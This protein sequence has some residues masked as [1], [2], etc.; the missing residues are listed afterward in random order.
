MSFKLISKHKPSGDQ[1]KAIESLVT[2]IKNGKKNQVLLGATGTGKTF[3]IANVIKNTNKSTIVLSHNKTLAGQLYTELKSLFPEN[4][5]EYFISN[6]DYY[7]PEAYMPSSDTFIDKTSKS[8]W[9]IEAMRMS[10]TNAMVSGEPVIVVA[11]VASIYGHRDPKEYQKTFLEF[12]IGQNIKRSD[13]LIALV[14]R[15]YTRNDI[16]N[17]P[18]T[19]RVRGDVI[20]IMPGF[21]DDFL[22]R[23]EQFGDEIEAIREVDYVTGEIKKS[24]E[25]YTIFPA[26][27]YAADPEVID[28]AVKTIRVELEER[29]KYFKENNKLLEAQR[30]EQRTLADIDSLEEYGVTSGI[31]N[32]SRHLDGR[33]AGARPFTILDYAVESATKRNDKPL[34]I[35]DESHMM[36]PQLNAMYNGDRSRK[37]NLVEYGFR[38]PSALDNRPL[39]FKEFE[40]EFPQFQKIYVSATPGDYELDLVEGEVISQIVRP[41]G[42]LDPTIEVVKTEG[43]VEDMFDK[44]Q[45][46]KKN[47][48]RTFILT[49]TKRMAE[50][51]TKYFQ[52]RNEKIAYIHSDHKTFQ[53]DEILRKLRIGVYDVVVGINLLKEGIDVPEVSLVLIIDADKESFFR[54]NKA[55][56]QIIGRAARNV[57]G[58]VVLYGDKVTKSMQ[59]AIDE[60]NRRRKIQK[61]YND[62]HG[63]IPKSIIKDIPEP[64]NPEQDNALNVLLDDS[65]DQQQ[66]IDSIKKNPESVKKEIQKIR[67][68][69]LK[70]ARE[71]D[72][73]RAAQMRDL[74]L[75]L[76]SLIN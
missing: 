9:D 66:K 50:E 4:R 63:I 64:L 40:N 35:I 53:R 71:M 68:K 26:D 31:E 38:L 20:E 54:S 14:Q 12:W 70:A 72:F 52:E 18:A 2:N 60:T 42:L 49:T 1:P 61:A 30:L 47:N 28:R 43:Q 3:T 67:G 17:K 51:L 15:N 39:K 74:I 10:A 62:E 16:D 65:M 36:I 23:I 44:I 58:H 37:E 45:E 11:S 13:I 21:A 25:K 22:V 59:N 27:A 55:L 32:Y 8:N 57:N 76:E 5:V 33:K 19:F 41:T 69:M 56:I 6:F 24:W 73:E 34:M 46:Q 75:E 48:R 7:R 29:L